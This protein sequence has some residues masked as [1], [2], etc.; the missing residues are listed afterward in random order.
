MLPSDNIAQM[1]RKLKKT[2]KEQEII[3]DNVESL[4][5][6]VRTK[7]GR[8]NDLCNNCYEKICVNAD[9]HVYPCASLN[10]DPNFD[11]GSVRKKSLKDIWLNSKAMKKGRN[12]SVQMKPECSQCYLEFFCGGGCTS[13][14]YYASEVAGGRGNVTATD[15]YCSTYKSLFEDII[16]ELASEGVP[17]QNGKGYTTPL[18]YNAMDSKLPSHLGSGIKSIDRSLR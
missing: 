18:V 13:H 15:P 2:Y 4:K 6:R 12:N 5:V 7:R 8:K 1:M 10:G 16:W 9:G 3:L 17:S 11:A 14:S